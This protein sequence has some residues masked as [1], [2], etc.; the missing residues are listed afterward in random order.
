MTGSVR[1]FANAN[2]PSENIPGSFRVPA[3]ERTI[4][5]CRRF[6]RKEWIQI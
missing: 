2:A 1:A 6:N 4:H 5:A 3:L